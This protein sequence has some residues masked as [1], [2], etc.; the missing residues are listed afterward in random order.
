MFNHTANF[1]CQEVFVHSYFIH[2]EFWPSIFE[3]TLQYDMYSFCSKSKGVYDVLNNSKLLS[4]NSMTIWVHLMSEIFSNFMELL[5][6]HV[7]DRLG[8]RG[9][10]VEKKCKFLLHCTVCCTFQ[11]FDLYLV[12]WCLEC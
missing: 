9:P 2:C 7:Q 12:V 10:K 6:V 5:F 3:W 8:K 1:E 4:H 11:L